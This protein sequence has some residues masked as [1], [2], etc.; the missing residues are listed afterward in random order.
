MDNEEATAFANAKR[1]AA[2]AE[3]ISRL[4]TDIA[5][6]KRSELAAAIAEDQAAGRSSPSSPQSER[7][8]LLPT[9]KRAFAM[10]WR[11]L[12]SE[13]E[14]ANCISL[15]SKERLLASS[16]L[17]LWPSCKLAQWKN[18]ASE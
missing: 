9:L 10:N 8:R 12:S 15:P 7:R 17:L 6:T 18:L 14:A 13:L 2:I 3:E 11:K 16:A 5:N 4:N 1:Q